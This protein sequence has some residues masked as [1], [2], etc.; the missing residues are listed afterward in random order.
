M[1]PGTWEEITITMFSHECTERDAWCLAPGRRLQLQCLVMNVQ[2]EMHGAWHMG[3]D[4][5]YNV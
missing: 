3:G 4:Y 5:N 2:K 1:V